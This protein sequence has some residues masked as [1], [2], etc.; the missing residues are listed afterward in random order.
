MRATK[1]AEVT[2]NTDIYVFNDLGCDHRF[3]IFTIVTKFDSQRNLVILWA[4][5]GW[6]YNISCFLSVCCA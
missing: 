6:D 3:S 5:V 1:N 2:F 4:W